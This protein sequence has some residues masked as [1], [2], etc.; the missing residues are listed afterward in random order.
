MAQGF[1]PYFNGTFHW[2]VIYFLNISKHT[3]TYMHYPLDKGSQSYI[4]IW[5]DTHTD[6][7]SFTMTRTI[8][9]KN[10]SSFSS[11]VKEGKQSKYPGCTAAELFSQLLGCCKAV[12]LYVD[13][14]VYHTSPSQSKTL[15]SQI[16]DSATM[17]TPVP[18]TL[19]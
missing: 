4:Y 12:K 8:F 9:H 13:L 1:P 15:P 14:P 16:P 11:G 10:I 19:C 5:V 2:L 7:I 17:D 6:P 3:H 18:I